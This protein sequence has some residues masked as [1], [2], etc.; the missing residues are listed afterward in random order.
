[1]TRRA[2]AQYNTI[3]ASA[4]SIAQ[5]YGSTILYCTLMFFTPGILLIP[6]IFLLRVVLLSTRVH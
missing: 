2:F 3:D 1:M 5:L 6:E 4:K